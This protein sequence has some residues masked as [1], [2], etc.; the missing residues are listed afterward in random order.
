MVIL[1]K[2]QEFLISFDSTEEPS[3]IKSSTPDINIFP[4]LKSTDGTQIEFT[5]WYGCIPCHQ[6]TNVTIAFLIS[7]LNVQAN[8]DLLLAKDIAA[9]GPAR[10]PWHIC[11]ILSDHRMPT[12]V[13]P[14]PA[15]NIYLNYH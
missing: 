2:Q 11:E 5:P 4:H 3:F 10:K 14:S 13:N 1:S 15:L 8:P 6:L 9:K 12:T 7:L